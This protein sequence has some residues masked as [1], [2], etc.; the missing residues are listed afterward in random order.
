[1]RRE[2]D[3]Y[4]LR[5]TLPG[6]DP[7]RDIDITV[8]DGNLTITAERIGKRYAGERSVVRRCRM[9][10]SVPLP[11]GSMAAEIAAEYVE[12]VLTVRIPVSGVANPGRRVPIV[13][14]G[15]STDCG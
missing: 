12:G 10:R 14:G 6:V 13:T 7:A 8:C 9:Q 5:A 15:E 1:V 4:T 3:C 2:R 11:P